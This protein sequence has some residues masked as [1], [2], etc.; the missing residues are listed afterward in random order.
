MVK[1]THSRVS[2]VIP[3]Y[4]MERYVGECLDSVV[5]QTHRDIEIIVVNDGSIDRSSTIVKKIARRDKRITLIDQPNGGVS[6]ARNTGMAASTGEYITFVDADDAIHPTYIENLLGDMQEA[7]AD[8]VSTPKHLSTEEQKERFLS[9]TIPIEPDFVV[10]GRMEALTALYNGQ[11]ERG[12]NGCQMFNADM[13][14]R[15]SLVFDT[16]MAIGEDFDFLARCIMA[17]QRV[18]VDNRALY[19]YR[20]NPDSAVHQDFD[21]RH[22]TAIKNMQKTGRSLQHP[23]KQLVEAMDNNLF[24]SSVSYGALMYA[25][26]K[27]FSKEFAEVKRN[28]RALKWHT[29]VSRRV[30]Y[31][32]R[33]RALLVICLGLNMGLIV[34]RKLIKI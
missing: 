5:A 12:N 10:F 33:I 15:H 31:S 22:F 6:A 19:Y 30:K 17:S 32:G 27:K 18:A 25:N 2:V 1:N 13:I 24:V 34:I 23:P 8:I 7:D 28:I 14:R 29:L 3:V 9:N 4:N 20:A 26:R 11:L 16:G 21:I